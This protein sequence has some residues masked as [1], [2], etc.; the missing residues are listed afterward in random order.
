M[1]KFGENFLR[2]NFLKKLRIY[3]ENYSLKF[4]NVKRKLIKFFTDFEN[5]F[6]G[7]INLEQNGNL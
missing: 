4:Q 7:K 5:V 2:E 1:K 6:K 3:L